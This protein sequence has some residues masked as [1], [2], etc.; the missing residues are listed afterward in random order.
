MPIECTVS[1]IAIS[2]KASK[3]I[4]SDM[5]ETIHETH[6]VPLGIGYYT[7]LEAAQDRAQE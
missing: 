5:L 3:D 6:V 2:T 1:V 4:F 7:V